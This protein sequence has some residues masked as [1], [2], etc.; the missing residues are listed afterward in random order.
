MFKLIGVRSGEVELRLNKVEMRYSYVEFIFTFLRECAFFS[1]LF[2]FYVK[3][4][5]K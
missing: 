5:I 4:K 2:C 3:R 1:V